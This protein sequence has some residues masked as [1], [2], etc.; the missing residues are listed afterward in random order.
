MRRREDFDR[1]AIVGTSCSGK[2]TLARELSRRLGTPHVELD[3]LFWGRTGRRDRPRNFGR[4]SIA[5]RLCST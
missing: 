2:S 5:R 3:E 1:V 4:A